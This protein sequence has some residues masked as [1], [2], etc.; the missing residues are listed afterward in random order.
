MVD[1][2]ANAP[3][4]GRL[5]SILLARKPRFTDSTNDTTATAKSKDGYTMAVSF[6][7]A[8][9]PQLSLFSIHCSKP[10]GSRYM[11]DPDF[12]IWPQLVGADGPFVLLRVGF[13]AGAGSR[14]Y[15]LY[16]AAGDAPASLERIPSPKVPGSDDDDLRGVREFG[17]LGHMAGGHYLLAALRDAPSSDDY[18]LRIYSSE[19]KSWSTRALQNPCPGVDR[20]VPDKVIT[21][22]QGGL[23]GWVDLSQGL[24]ACDLLRLQDPDP[25]GGGG[26]ASFFIPMPEPLPGNRYKEKYPIPPT[27]KMKKHPLLEEPSRSASW[28]R[29]L[30]CVNGVL[31]FIEMENPAPPENKDDIISDSDLI[32][33]L[34]RKAVDRNSEQHLSS[35]RND[36]RAVTWSREV[37]PSSAN[38]WR[39]T[40]A[41]PVAKIKG[42]EQLL[43]MLIKDT[44]QLVT[45]RDL[46]SAFPILSPAD[47]D[48]DIL[49]LKSLVEPSHRDG[50]VAAVNIGKETLEELA[51]YYL[52]DDWYYSHRFNPEHP[53]SACTLSSH[54]DITPG[55]CSCRSHAYAILLAIL[56]FLLAIFL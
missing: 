39:Q 12:L 47:N 14:E 2:A 28:F 22:G 48:H 46:Y 23:L 43:M 52:P 8:D 15:F 36:W 3:N 10:P 45:F 54:M 9:P 50:W 20:V 35:F 42:S 53:F 27:K 40:C 41:T 33:W 19:T 55:T 1:A 5:A 31:K 51:P 4:Q 17:I 18:Q 30:A 29:D 56:I 21:L 26:G 24:L 13:Y 11:M 37:S 16:K 38:F 49:Y 25:T 7:I 6:W 32:M 34:K 44:Q